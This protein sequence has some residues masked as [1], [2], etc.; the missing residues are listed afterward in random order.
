MGEHTFSI[1]DVFAERKYAG[2]QLAVFKDAHDLSDSEMQSF[3]KEMNYS[4]TTFILSEEER[5]GGYDVRIF[6]PEEEIPFAGHPSLG[7][8]YII[9]LQGEDIDD[10][11]P[12]QAVSTGL[13][14]I[15]VPLKTLEAVKR[16]CVVQEKYFDLIR[17]REAKDILIFCPETYSREVERFLWWRRESLCSGPLFQPCSRLS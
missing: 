15:I 8:A 9:Q 13:P 1:V 16:A 12:V 5:D 3:A 6:T 10:G 17:D 4:E 11:C 14:F 7:T 2:N